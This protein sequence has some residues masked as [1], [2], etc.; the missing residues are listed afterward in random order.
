MTPVVEKTWEEAVT[1]MALVGLR[2][3][4]V[5]EWLQAVDAKRSEEV[6]HYQNSEK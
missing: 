3:W 1:R 2:R 4:P 5:V 6:V